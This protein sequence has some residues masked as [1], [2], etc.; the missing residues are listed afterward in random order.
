MGAAATTGV[1]VVFHYGRTVIVGAPY[2]S[3]PLC[4]GRGAPRRTMYV[5]IRAAAPA[6]ANV[7][8]A[9]RGAAPHRAAC[10]SRRHATRCGRETPT[11][12]HSGG[13]RCR[14]V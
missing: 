14:C 12:G 7:A 9:R 4:R 13:S 10:L 6:A 5:C 2:V 11:H 3:S 8:A 1:H